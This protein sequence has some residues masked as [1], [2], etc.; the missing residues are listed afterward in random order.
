[1]AYVDAMNLGRTL[2]DT[3]QGVVGRP[4]HAELLTHLLWRLLEESYTPEALITECRR[5]ARED[6]GLPPEL[7]LGPEPPPPHPHPL[8]GPLRL[9]PGGAGYVDDRGPVLPVGCHAGDLLALYARDPDWAEAELDTIAAAGYQAVRTWTVLRGPYWEALGRVIVPDEGPYWEAVARFAEALRRRRLRWLVSQGDLMA[10]YHTTDGRQAVMW[11]L[12]AALR[13][14][15]GLDLVAAVDGGNET[16]KNGESDP[17]RLRDAV[18]AFREVLD[19]PVWSLTSPQ[20]ASVD[21]IDH[22]AGSVFDVHTGRGGTQVDMVR[23]AFSAGYHGPARRTGIASEGPGVGRIED[24]GLVSGMDVNLTAPYAVLLAAVQAMARQLPVFFSSPGVSVR[25]RDEFLNQPGAALVPRLIR[26]LPAD[27]MTWPTLIH[28]GETWAGRGRVL[29]VTDDRTRAD[30][31]IGPNGELVVACYG[32]L[33]ELR[34]RLDRDAEVNILRCDDLSETEAT[35]PAG[36]TLALDGPAVLIGR[37][38]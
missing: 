9:G 17:A 34:Y 33:S 7:P 32:E 24:G 21:E 16:W 26:R 28:G 27:L 18:D 25:R 15:G 3:Y 23:H 1:M 29:A 4:I 31:A 37:T 14:A 6:A 5:R 2:D 10:E 22:Y 12:A 38:T 36:S 20:V 19:V 8:E 13:D 30:Q 11:A 35:L